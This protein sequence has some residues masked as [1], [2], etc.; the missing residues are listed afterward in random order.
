LAPVQCAGWGHPV[1]TGHDTIDYFLTAGAMEPDGADG[2]YVESLVRLPGIG[3]SYPRPATTNQPLETVRAQLRERLR[4]PAGTPLFLCPQALFKI[5]PEDD[6][7]FARVLEAVPGS[8]LL[9]FEG[10]H[11]AVTGQFLRRLGLA[12]AAH[13]LHG[14]ERL[15]VLA[16]M[17]RQDFLQVNAACEAMLDTQQWSG[18]NTSLDAVA[19]GLPIVALPGRFMRGRQS[20]AMLR[21]V[22]AAELIAADADD[23]VRIAARL[24]VDSTWRA[25]IGKRIAIGS[26]Q[27]FDDPEALRAL[28][29]FLRSA[30]GSGRAR[31]A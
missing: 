3:T 30:A 31:S 23:Y 15:R 22:G 1:T 14:G 13:G 11:R 16:L 4:L 29:A 10:R 24:A 12:L 18:G 20:A 21:M 28:D 8:V 9:V 19:A 6:A 25:E 27:L 5:L 26:V 7:L 17:P 2:H